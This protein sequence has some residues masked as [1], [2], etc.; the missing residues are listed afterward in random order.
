MEE[1]QLYPSEKARELTEMYLSEGYH[2]RE[3]ISKAQT[4]CC[5]M[6]VEDKKNSTFWAMTGIKCYLAYSKF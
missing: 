5:K 3:S 1:E 4:Y 2:M 6:V